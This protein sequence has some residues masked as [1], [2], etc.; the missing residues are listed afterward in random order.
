MDIDAKRKTDFVDQFINEL[1]TKLANDD[2]VLEEK[3]TTEIKEIIL[4]GDLKSSNEEASS[5]LRI[6]SEGKT[7]I[8]TE[9]RVMAKEASV[10]VSQWSEENIASVRAYRG[11]DLETNLVIETIKSN[12]NITEEQIKTVRSLAD[13]VNKIYNSDGGVENQK[14]AVVAKNEVTAKVKFAWRDTQGIIGL[15]KQK[16]KEFKEIVDNHEEITTKLEND[17]IKVPY[18]SSDKL[19]SYD[20]VMSSI[21]NPEMKRFIESARS[22]FKTI[23]RITNGKFS[24]VSN[25]VIN[26]IGGDRLRNV[27]NNFFNKSIVNISNGFASKIGNQAVKEFVQNSISSI[28]K[29]GGISQG[30]KSLMQGVMK[31]G[32]EMAGKTAVNLA[33]KMGLSAGLKT[34]I[35]A[36]FGAATGGLGYIAM[37]GLEV[38]NMGANL[39]RSL[40][41]QITKSKLA[42]TVILIILIIFGLLFGMGSST[43]GL[44]SSLEPKIENKG[45]SSQHGEITMTEDGTRI[46]DCGV[47][48]D[49][50]FNRKD[51]KTW[52]TPS[53]LFM[54]NYDE[55]LEEY[56][57]DAVGTACGVV[58]A[59]H[60]LAYDF[61]Y[62]IPYWLTGSWPKK[63]LNPT[64]GSHAVS[65]WNGHREGPSGLDCGHFR[66]WAW[67][68]GGFSAGM[69]NK[70]PNI[71]FGDCE[72][73]KAAI[74]PGDG[75]YMDKPPSING[76]KTY[77]HSAIVLAYDD[78]YIKFAH[79][80]GGSG[81]TTGLI[82]ICTGVG[83]DNGNHFD[84][85][86]KKAY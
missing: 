86:Q 72:R 28:L 16:P 38:L 27:A 55:K 71:P 60:Y 83:V 66:N 32:V 73:I 12:P 22:R 35:G 20:R 69:S 64:W 43:T 62:W 52:V 54:E 36:A 74:E 40:G 21:K 50:D 18:S 42:D 2:K 57:G 51:H 80:G 37:A 26:R 4:Q 58:Y 44:V 6:L 1:A 65:D 53:L 9:T 63:G 67:V 14:D 30:I 56:I 19:N 82:N 31:K 3:L 34:A 81:V 13:N 78:N 23:D 75:L 77:S 59:A 61:D 29:N 70:I 8:G 49:V 39:L 7:E 33:A 45:G 76:K 79:A 48:M 41:L 47:G 25:N 10:K 24:Q 85:L 17:N 11:N 15:L 68:N 84:S 5:L 46:R